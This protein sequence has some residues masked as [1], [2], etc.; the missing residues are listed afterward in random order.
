MCRHRKLQAIAKTKASPEN[1]NI[2]R[3]YDDND[4]VDNDDAILAEAVVANACITKRIIIA[5]IIKNPYA[6]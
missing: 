4:G 5:I 1:L 3:V 6:M 2:Y